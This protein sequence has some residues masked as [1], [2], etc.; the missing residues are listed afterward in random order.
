MS[1]AAMSVRFFHGTPTNTTSPLAGR[2][3]RRRAPRP[4]GPSNRRRARPF[5]H[6][7][8][9]RAASRRRSR[10]PP[11]RLRAAGGVG[12]DECDFVA[13]KADVL[14][15]KQPHRSRARGRDAPNTDDDGNPS[16]ER[17]RKHLGRRSVHRT[18]DDTGTALRDHRVD[19]FRLPDGTVLR[20]GEQVR[21][22]FL[23]A[24]ASKAATMSLKK[25][26]TM[27]FK[28]TPRRLD[29]PVRSCAAKS[30]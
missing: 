16:L 24:D 7:P 4:R 13:A 8:D 11:P 26:L 18:E 20:H 17:S 22:R 2:S 19:E 15:R 29:R 5:A 27:L 25:G 3:G 30:S 12:L 6:R 14:R 1:W 23:Q 10:R 9:P 21:Y 28:I